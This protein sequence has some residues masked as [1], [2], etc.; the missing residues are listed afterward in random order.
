[1]T[2]NT[3][4][5][6]GDQGDGVVVHASEAALAVQWWLIMESSGGGRFLEILD[7]SRAEMPPMVAQILRTKY[8]SRTSWVR[9]L[10]N[11][12][13]LFTKPIIMKAEVSS[14]GNL[15]SIFDD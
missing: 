11:Q 14:V 2:Y 15:Y 6:K 3:S 5:F 9:A 12:H 4:M 8:Y 1:M 10:F 13:I 7:L